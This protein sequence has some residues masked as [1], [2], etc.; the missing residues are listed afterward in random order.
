M[1]GIGLPGGAALA[2]WDGTQSSSNPAL[3]AVVAGICCRE[4]L[5]GVL[6]DLAPPMLI[7]SPPACLPVHLPPQAVLL[8]QLD[9]VRRELVEVVARWGPHIMFGKELVREVLAFAQ[10][11]GRSRT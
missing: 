1:V 9:G 8:G 4:R 3:R 5:G 7:C 11:G 2:L 6:L 10:V